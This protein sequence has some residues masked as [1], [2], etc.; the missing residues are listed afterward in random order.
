[1]A[2]VAP[3]VTTV[4]RFSDS[5]EEHLATRQAVGLFDFSFMACFEITGPQGLPFLRHLQPRNLSGLRPGRIMYTLL[6]RDDGTVY[7]DATLWCHTPTRYWLFTGRRTDRVHIERAAVGFNVEIRD[8][9]PRHAVI[10]LQ[11]PR[12]PDLL[13]RVTTGDVSLGYYQFTSAQVLGCQA[14][15]GRIGYSG[16][17]GYELI[18][19]ANR[20]PA[21]WKGLCAI[22]RNL[23]VRECGFAAADSLRI[24]AG[25]LLFARELALPVT[26]YMLGLKR[27]LSELKTSYIGAQ[28]LRSLRGKDPSACL[29]GLLPDGSV[30]LVPL[31]P[32]A[33]TNPADIRPGQG[34]IT[35]ACM[36]PIFNCVLALGY[37][38]HE[39]RYPGTRVRLP[40]NYGARVARLPFYDPL[41]RL[42]RI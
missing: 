16:E 18:V 31:L 4:L 28:A 35:S 23:G 22:G 9:A 27:L 2:E 33:V 21:V 17:K 34:C 11:G 32:S 37:V 29:V 42:P 39:D 6:C 25:F 19:A 5:R 1:M 41:K 3:G 15:I 10:A 8:I 24:E 36:S 14:W 20:A 7:N 38:H 13:R 26:P 12:S 30:D 40:G